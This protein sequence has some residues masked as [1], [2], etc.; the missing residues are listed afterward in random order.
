VYVSFVPSAGVAFVTVFVIETFAAEVGLTEAE[1][2]VVP[3][4]FGFV[5]VS[6]AM[7]VIVLELAFTVTVIVAVALAD[8]ASVPMVQVTV[9]TPAT[10]ASE[11]E[12]VVV[13]ELT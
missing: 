5:W 1:A 11:I 6:L 3:V 9:C 13:A 2:E 12:P 4:G 7:F 8:L 10:R